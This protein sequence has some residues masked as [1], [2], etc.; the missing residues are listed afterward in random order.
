MRTYW[1]P[2]PAPHPYTKLALIEVQSRR[3]HVELEELTDELVEVARKCGA[4]AVVGTTKGY[5]TDER[6]HIIPPEDE[7]AYDYTATVVSG[8][9]VVFDQPPPDPAVVE[10]PD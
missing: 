5:M 2:E 10:W 6:F 7:G 8:I 9:A 1:G 3:Q 4:D